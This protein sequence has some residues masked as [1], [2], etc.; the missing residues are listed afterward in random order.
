MA[1]RIQRSED[2][3]SYITEAKIQKAVL[4]RKY[5]RNK[6]LALEACFGASKR[7]LAIH[8]TE[9]TAPKPVRELVKNSRTRLDNTFEDGEWHTDRVRKS[10]RAF[11]A[12]RRICVTGK[13]T[14][15]YAE[16]YFVIE[17]VDEMS[18][19]EHIDICPNDKNNE[20]ISVSLTEILA[21]LH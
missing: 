20:W 6:K 15:A 11:G 8:L 21:K 5:V 10:G 12:R 3:K 2:A 13:E 7:E 14:P 1:W 19:D 18:G 9:L 17:S 16:C 4:Y